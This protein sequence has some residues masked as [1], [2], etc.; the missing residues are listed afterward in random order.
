M[1]TTRKLKPMYLYRLR[2]LAAAPRFY[3]P[4]ALN[5]YLERRGLIARTGRTHPDETSVEYAITGAGREAL[6]S[7]TLA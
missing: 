5:A 3:A 2:L 4:S 7:G 1:A 6:G